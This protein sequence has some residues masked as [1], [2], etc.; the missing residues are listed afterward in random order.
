M[1][2]TKVDPARAIPLSEKPLT[3]FEIE[4]LR[5]V[6][7]GADIYSDQVAKCCR[8]LEAL[9]LVEVTPAMMPERTGPGSGDGVWFGCIITPAGR[10]A[11]RELVAAK[12]RKLSKGRK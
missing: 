3:P 7:K 5:G 1:S 10:T 4:T 2:F 9:G 12:G 11:L 8:G 6:R